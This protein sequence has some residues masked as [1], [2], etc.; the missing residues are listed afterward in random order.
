V[1]ET[2]CTL[3]ETYRTMLEMH[4]IMSIVLLEKGIEQETVLHI[5]C[6]HVVYSLF[7]I[8]SFAISFI[9]FLAVI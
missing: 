3:L 4:Y 5:S 9:L 1:R 2:V 8:F 7:K 6:I